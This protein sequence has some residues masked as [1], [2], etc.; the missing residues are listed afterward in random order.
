MFFL[1]NRYA[2][3]ATLCPVNYLVLTLVNIAVETQVAAV[4]L[5]IGASIF[6]TIIERIH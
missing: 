2:L 1:E 5:Y 3:L 4:S 6:L